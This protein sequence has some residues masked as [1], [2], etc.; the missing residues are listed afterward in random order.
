M[1][2]ENFLASL[3]HKRENLPNASPS[4]YAMELYESEMTG[5]GTKSFDLRGTKYGD[6]FQ[7][8]LR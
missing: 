8:I 6:Y 4:D 1:P 5:N 3:I 2:L 7:I